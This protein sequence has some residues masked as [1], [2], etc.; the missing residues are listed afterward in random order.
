MTNPSDKDFTGEEKDL[1]F[2]LKYGDVVNENSTATI[3]K[4]GGLDIPA[5][6]FTPIR[7]PLS[8]GNEA[9]STEPGVRL[10]V[11][12]MSDPTGQF[13]GT[14]VWIDGRRSLPI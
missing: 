11:V 2:F 13:T 5:T 14:P 7:S 10:A 12:M 4:F 9:R 1:Y 6:P 8:F 3:R